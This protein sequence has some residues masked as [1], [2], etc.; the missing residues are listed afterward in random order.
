MLFC[1]RS[2]SLASIW[3]AAIYSLNVNCSWTAGPN[4]AHEMKNIS[5]LE[6]ELCC[7]RTKVIKKH[8]IAYQM[9][10]INLNKIVCTQTSACT[11]RATKKKKK[12][13]AY[14]HGDA[15]GTIE[16]NGW[17]HL[18]WN[19]T[20]RL[21]ILIFVLFC[22]ENKKSLFFF[23]SASKYLIKCDF[24]NRQQKK[25]R[26]PVSW[27]SFITLAGLIF[28]SNLKTFAWEFKYKYHQKETRKVHSFSTKRR[29]FARCI[30]S[31]ALILWAT[32]TFEW[33]FQHF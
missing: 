16:E 12:R 14:T 33:T 2:F 26:W 17:V 5:T 19:K 3:F 28:L 15:R 18:S 11:W 1:L 24:V 27:F 23:T 13:R 21:L 6:N 32:I 4:H 20:V 30:W 22:D 10:D 29:H 8:Q 31:K 9:N 25:I 7:I